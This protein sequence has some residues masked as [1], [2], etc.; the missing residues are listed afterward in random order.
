MGC[1]WYV[2]DLHVIGVVGAVG[3]QVLDEV[4]RE[5]GVVGPGRDEGRRGQPAG[6]VAACQQAAD[7]GQDHVPD[8]G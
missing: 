6:A 2:R 5:D 1:S 3:Q 7:L 8:H 4:G